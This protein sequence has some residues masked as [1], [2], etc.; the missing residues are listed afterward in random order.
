M[1][2]RTLLTAPSIRKEIYEKDK[3]TISECKNFCESGH[4]IIAL[5]YKEPYLKTQ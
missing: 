4:K 1:Y 5:D 2:K 3:I